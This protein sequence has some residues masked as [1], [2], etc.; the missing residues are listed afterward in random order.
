[1]CVRNKICSFCERDAF[2]G[3]VLYTSMRAYQIVFFLILATLA[4]VCLAHPEIAPGQRVR[5]VEVEVPSAS[6]KK[7]VP[8][9]VVLPS[10]YA[11][12]D[13]RRYPVVYMLHGAGND[14]RTYACEPI[15]SLADRI[16]AIVVCPYG[17]A[18]WWMDSPQMPHMRY[19]TFVTKELVPYV[20]GHYRT[21]A[22]RSGRAIAGHSMG[23]HG[24]C[25][26]GFGHAD[27]FGA[28]GNVMGGVDL[29]PFATRPDL[30]KL[31]G[32]PAAHPDDWKRF[33]AISRAAKLRNGEVQFTTVV[34]T[35]DF[36][37]DVNRAMHDLLS[38]NRVAHVHQEIRGIDEE[39]ST[40]TRTFAYEAMK[41][42]FGRFG[43]YFKSESK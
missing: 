16:G 4:T 6:M 33:S 43:E 7:D 12:S 19:E 37:L 13:S 35:G 20:D 17:G 27:L 10:N 24:A 2:S 21:V 15:L 30:L 36:F 22:D 34:G 11:D 31:L 9:T 8:T 41:T 14:R 5:V 29:R 38:S 40:H 3:M 26:I 39:H 25:F 32:D 1:M 28:V 23:G 42:V 18:S